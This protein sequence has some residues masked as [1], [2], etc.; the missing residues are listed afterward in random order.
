M[1]DNFQVSMK[2]TERSS[3]KLRLDLPVQSLSS[4]ANLC[5][6]RPE[7]RFTGHVVAIF[8]RWRIRTPL[9]LTINSSNMVSSMPSKASL[10]TGDLKTLRMLT[11]RVCSVQLS[12][13]PRSTSRGIKKYEAKGY[14][15]LLL[16]VEKRLVQEDNLP[17]DRARR[18]EPDA[19]NSG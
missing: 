3:R 11:S 17:L 5:N 18:H 14:L 13:T 9:H 19:W 10:D 16:P 7:R 4:L 1:I 6:Q 15:R 2:H 12:A 8:L